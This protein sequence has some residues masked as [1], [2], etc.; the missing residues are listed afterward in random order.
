M[1][2]HY[3]NEHQSLGRGIICASDVER[4][5]NFEKKIYDRLILPPLLASEAGKIY[6]AAVGPGILQCWL[7]SHGI[8]EV[9]GCDISHK[10]IDL[11]KNFNARIVK[12]DA[13]K[14]LEE[15]F[16]ADSF[17]LIVALDFYEHLERADFS[18]F[19]D[20]AFSRLQ[21]GGTLI[22]RGPNGDSPLVGTNFYNDVT[23][24]WAY[25]T[26]SLRALLSISGFS[27]IS[28]VDDTKSSLHSGRWWKLPL[29]VFAQHLLTWA[30]YAASR[31]QIKYWGAS[32]Y[33]FA[34]K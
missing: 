14:D 1:N 4:I 19:L 15:R 34:R 32:I 24:V 3:I 23:H 8:S 18:K 27:Q 12:S 20:I 31:V 26:Q 10:E 5:A 9:E 16:A 21:P 25:T 22:L 6:E 30:F 7:K 17:S 28:F 13:I 11:A 2:P 29:M 33:V